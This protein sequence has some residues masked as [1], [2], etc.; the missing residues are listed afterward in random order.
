MRIPKVYVQIIKESSIIILGSPI[1]LQRIL[2][3][4]FF[5]INGNIDAKVSPKTGNKED[6][7]LIMKL[8]FAASSVNSSIGIIAYSELDLMF[9]KTL[10]NNQPAISIVGIEINIP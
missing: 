8:G 4:S 1:V 2:T 10:E 7:I 3:C 9:F 6:K 5:Q